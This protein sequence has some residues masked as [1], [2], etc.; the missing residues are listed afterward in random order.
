VETAL[1]T[2]NIIGA[3][4][5]SSFLGLTYLAEGNAA[6]AVE[7]CRF[8]RDHITAAGGTW[9]FSMIGSHLADAL[10]ANG[11]VDEALRVAEETIKVI[12]GG[13]HWGEVYLFTALGR[14]HARRRALLD[15]R[16]AFQ[17]A[18][19]VAEQQKSPVFQAKARF[20]MGLFLLSQGE[21]DAGL[22][23]LAR[24]QEGFAALAMYWHLAR[25]LAVLGGA[26]DIGPCP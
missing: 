9:T 17:R 6:R 4:T 24:A 3:G 15:A 19:D 22:A 14:I 13:E 21:R 12:D 8:G 23:E 20:A 2:G 25:V 11:E 18:M 5:G 26:D 10:L 1:P 16:R 7:L